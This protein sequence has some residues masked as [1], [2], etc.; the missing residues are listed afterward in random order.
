MNNGFPELSDSFLLGQDIL[1]SQ[2]NDINFY[3]ED[4]DQEHFYFN[5][6]SKL[7]PNVSFEK[8]FPLNGKDNVVIESKL[9]TDDKTKVYIVDLDF[10]EILNKKENKKNLFY[11]K[12]YSIE[13]YLC[14]KTSLYE[15]IR[16]KNPKLKNNEIDALF[17]FEALQEQWKVLLSELSSIFIIIQKFSLGKE[18]FGINCH[19][20]F[21]CNSTPPTYRNQFLT[22]YF[23]EIEILLKNSD[24]SYTLNSEINKLKPNYL[25]VEEAI[26]NI[27]GKYILTLL[28]HQLEN[29]GLINQVNLESFTYKLSKECSTNNLIYLRDGIN[30]YTE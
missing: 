21:D 9:T 27:P 24:D 3:V 12:K 10:D 19:R 25:N 22:N 20:D 26:K 4:T 30:E 2:F 23:N 17:N 14:D 29:L 8:I 5:I 28:K 7:F 1:Y 15:I 18:Y 6:L 11:L 13:N 16:E